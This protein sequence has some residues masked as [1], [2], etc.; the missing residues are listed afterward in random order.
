MEAPMPKKRIPW[1][2]LFLAE[3]G[4]EAAGEKPAEQR[5]EDGKPASATAPATGS[6][7][8]PSSKR[9]PKSERQ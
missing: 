1:H 2:P 3:D 5:A 6:P 4:A 8:R 9:N 7:A